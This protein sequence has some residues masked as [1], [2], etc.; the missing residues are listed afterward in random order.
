MVEMKRISYKSGDNKKIL[1]Y[2]SVP[3]GEKAENLPVIIFPH[4][5]PWLRDSWGYNNIVQFFCNRGYA[6]LQMNYRG[7]KGYGK[8]FYEAGFKEWGGK[9][10]DDIADGAEWL[11]KQGIADEERIAIFGYSFGGYSSLMGMIKNPDLYKCGVSYCG[12]INLFGF[13]RSVP[14]YWAPFK[15]MLYET[16]GNPAKDSIKLADSSPYHNVEKIKQPLFIAQG[17]ND[18]KVS[19]KDANSFVKKLKEKKNMV[20][21]LV[22]ENEGHTF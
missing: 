12:V 17:A 9:I 19:I 4:G 18:P 1:G 14:D 10:Q 6:V 22:K 13:L 21:Y 8:K 5:G 7:S 20:E 2:L 11:I 16:I 15:D 3:V